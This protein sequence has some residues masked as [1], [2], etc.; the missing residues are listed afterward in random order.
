MDGLN[1]PQV[2]DLIGELFFA[3]SI[4]TAKVG[5][6]GV[7]SNLLFILGDFFQLTALSIF[8]GVLVNNADFVPLKTCNVINIMQK[9]VA[10][11]TIALGLLS[12]WSFFMAFNVN[13]FFYL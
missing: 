5:N 8:M 9:V 7:L 6:I 2:L 12:L 13:G 4:L 3:F 11:F 10:I 1:S